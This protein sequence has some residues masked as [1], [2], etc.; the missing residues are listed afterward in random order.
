MQDLILIVHLVSL[1]S[2]S[3]PWVVIRAKNVRQEHIRRL[4]R[5]HHR[6]TVR[7]AH[8]ESTR[9]FHLL[10]QKCFVLTV[11]PVS[12]GRRQA[13]PRIAKRAR[14]TQDPCKAAPGASATRTFL[15]KKHANGAPH[16]HPHPLAQSHP[17]DA[18]ASQVTLDHLFP[19][20]LAVLRASSKRA[21]EVPHALHA[22]KTIIRRQTPPK[23]P[24][25]T[26]H[27]QLSLFFRWMAIYQCLRSLMMWR[28]ICSGVLH[29]HSGFILIP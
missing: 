18:S 25:V 8:V 20:A 5:Q 26:Q 4:S 21:R 22:P 6:E 14:K 3:Q 23:C 15:A 17:T 13:G 10:T 28:M 27:Q 29:K 24:N 7:C 16:I 2:T 1:E 11:Q 9:C 19:L 12:L